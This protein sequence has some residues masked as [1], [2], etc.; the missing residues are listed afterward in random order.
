MEKQFPTPLLKAGD[1]VSLFFGDVNEEWPICEMRGSRLGVVVSNQEMTI[2]TGLYLV[3]PISS[4]FTREKDNITIRIP[5]GGKAT[6]LVLCSQVRTMDLFH[7]KNLRN[8]TREDVVVD[9]LPQKIVEMIQANIWE[10][11]F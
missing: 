4:R 8:K 9:T 11:L 1:V 3:C 2:R 10:C 5:K 7:R 6:G